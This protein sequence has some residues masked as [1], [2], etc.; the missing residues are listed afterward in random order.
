MHRR[1]GQQLWRRAGVNARVPDAAGLSVS[2]DNGFIAGRSCPLSYRYTPNSLSHLHTTETDTLYCVGGL[3]G[4]VF[5][6]DALESLLKTESATTRVV[7]NGDFHWFD[8]TPDAFGTIETRSTR[9]ARYARLRGNVETEIASDNDIGCG[10][11][12]PDAVDDGVVDRS[13]EILRELR[14]ASVAHP[15]GQQMRAALAALPMCAAHR[16]GGK[17]VVAVHGD[18]ESLAG[19]RLDPKSLD[20]PD[21]ENWVQNAMSAADADIVA[22]SHTCLPA[23]RQFVSKSAL[24]TV[25]NNGAAGMPCFSGTQFGVVTRISRT[26]AESVGHTAL[27]GVKHADLWVEALALEF[28]LD[29]WRTHFLS[30]WPDGTAAHQSYFARIESGVNFSPAQALAR[31]GVGGAL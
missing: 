11:A 5:A 2:D 8:A 6:L 21:A 20:S 22:S 28:E 25:V 10:C 3:Y 24:R 18:L 15:N 14:S 17:R 9:S 26:S 30:M 29:T 31:V 23:L 1:A 12:Y 19:W 4:N 13:N 16:V 7:F 27:Y